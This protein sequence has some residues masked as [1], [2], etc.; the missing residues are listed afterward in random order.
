[1]PEQSPAKT[2]SSSLISEYEISVAQT[3]ADGVGCGGDVATI[4]KAKGLLESKGVGQGA[5][6]PVLAVGCAIIYHERKVE[7]MILCNELVEAS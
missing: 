7:N 3:A 6:V 2:Q 4:S 1:M 5:F